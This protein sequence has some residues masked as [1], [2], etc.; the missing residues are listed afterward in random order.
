MR[1][2]DNRRAA[3]GCPSTTPP[4]SSARFSSPRHPWPPSTR[5]RIP[6]AQPWS[7]LLD[8]VA[9]QL[10]LTTRIPFDEWL[11][12][13]VQAADTAGSTRGYPVWKLQAFFTRLFQ[14]AVC[15]HVILAT[16]RA[17]ACAPT[18][19]RMRAVEDEVVLRFVQHWREIGYFD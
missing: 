1:R 2:R 7:D 19:R 6:F 14:P 5:L 4:P 13:V 11:A 3:R 10:G 15:G 17:R 9:P 16:D 8:T 12:A 18:L